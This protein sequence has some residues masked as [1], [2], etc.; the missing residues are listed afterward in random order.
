MDVS[1]Y[2]MEGSLVLARAGLELW[3]RHDGGAVQTY[4]AHF[5]LDDQPEGPMAVQLEQY[6]GNYLRMCF[7]D[8]DDDRAAPL[9]SFHLTSAASSAL[10]RR[11]EGAEA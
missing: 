1:V 11:V 6:W 4:A 9:I 8:G 7:N 3:Y 5:L 10:F 2:T